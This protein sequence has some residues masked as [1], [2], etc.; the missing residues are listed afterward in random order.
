MPINLNVDEMEKLVQ[1][2]VSNSLARPTLRRIK[3][4]TA[5][6]W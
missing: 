6:E 5:G 3:Q 2:G 1:L 4:G